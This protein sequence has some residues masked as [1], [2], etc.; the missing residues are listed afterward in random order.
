MFVFHLCLFLKK[1]Y[2]MWLSMTIPSI[3]DSWSG[4]ATLNHTNVV[5][6][7]DIGTAGGGLTVQVKGLFFFFFKK[8]KVIFINCMHIYFFF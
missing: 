6:E 2:T 8:T 5:V 3:N 4:N 7:I 1:R